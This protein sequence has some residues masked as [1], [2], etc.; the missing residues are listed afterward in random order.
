MVDLIDDA[1]ETAIKVSSNAHKLII[2]NGLDIS[3]L[4]A[5]SSDNTNVNVGENHSIYSLF[6]DEL[7]NLMKGNT[8]LMS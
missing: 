2:D 6:R 5:L 7:P 8:N 4:T 3:G 1:D